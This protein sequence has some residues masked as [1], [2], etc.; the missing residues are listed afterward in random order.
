[1]GY[2]P[3]VNGRGTCIGGGW[4]TL[5][6]G[7]GWGTPLQEGTWDQWS[8]YRMEMGYSLRKDMGPG[9]VEVLWDGD[10]GTPFRLPTDRLL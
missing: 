8:Y 4:G 9:E 7:T 2:P 10:G 3:S 6:S 5:T 1:M